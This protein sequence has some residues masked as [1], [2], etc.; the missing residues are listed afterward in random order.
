M[1]TF[2]LFVHSLFVIGFTIRVLVREDLGASAR[3]AWFVVLSG[4]PFVGTAIYFLFG[5]IDIGNK[6]QVRHDE[7]FAEI[8]ARGQAFMGRAED[9]ERLIDPIYQPAFKY[10]ASINGFQ[11]IA[12]NSAELLEDASAFRD[13]LITD[14]DQATSHVHVLYYIWLDDVTGGAVANALMR[15]ARR[16][17]TCRAIADALGSRALIKSK[18]WS[19]MEAAGVHLAKAFPLDNPIR[20]VL[21]SRFDLRNHRK[22]TVIDGKITYCG[23]QNSADPEFRV[24]PKY[25]PW[26]DIM[27]RF[28]GPVVAQNQL[29][30]ASDWKQATGH[31]LDGSPVMAAPNPN[32]FPALV[33]GDG[34][35]ERRAATPQFF[36]TLL[37]CASHEICVTTPYFVPDPTVLEALCA[38]AHRGVNVRLNLPQNN[39]SWIVAAASRSFYHRLLAAGCMIEEY[40]EGLLH[41]KILTIDSEVSFIGSSNLD[42]RSFDLNYENNILL[43]DPALTR[44]IRARQAEYLATSES[45]TLNDA[46][47]WPFYQRIWQNAVA[48]V[49]PIL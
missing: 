7:I 32:G 35:T 9:I 16:G 37:A 1:W 20:T 44:A 21:K 25:A 42:I 49:G 31:I 3:L 41:A 39:D 6:A 11:P 24:K 38:A 12:G 26:V 27:V 43:Q 40:T 18:L 33:V 30:F 13:R 17:V 47:E 2:F 4:F 23:S 29:L 48:T 19:E 28:V 22:I 10:A 36:A 5:E 14:I 45:V 34:P 15:A 8:R 46:L